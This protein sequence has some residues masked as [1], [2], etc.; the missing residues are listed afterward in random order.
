MAWAAAQGNAPP[1]FA[2]RDLKH[3]GIEVEFNP[4][5]KIGLVMVTAGAG[6]SC[7]KPDCPTHATWKEVISTEVAVRVFTAYDRVHAQNAPI[8]QDILAAGEEIAGPGKGGNVVNKN[9]AEKAW[10]GDSQVGKNRMLWLANT[11]QGFYDAMNAQGEN[12]GEYGKGKCCTKPKKMF[13]MLVLTLMF[14]AKV[15]SESTYI[16]LRN[17]ERSHR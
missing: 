17:L 14:P 11:R 5:G 16:T 15:V 9:G 13:E 4:L 12:P 8:L 1:P 6:T 2:T 3:G 7:A 10:G